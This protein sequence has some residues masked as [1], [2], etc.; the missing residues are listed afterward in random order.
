M[1][2]VTKKLMVHQQWCHLYP[3]DLDDVA[4]GNCY[5]WACI[6]GLTQA[7]SRENADSYGKTRCCLCSVRGC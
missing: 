4:G 3:Y 2:L 7:Q 5:G 1:V 6:M